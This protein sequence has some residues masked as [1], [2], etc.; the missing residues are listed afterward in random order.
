VPTSQARR[1]L[2]VCQGRLAALA[3][4]WASHSCRLRG[5]AHTLN[6]IRRRLRLLLGHLFFVAF[7]AFP[8]LLG[9]DDLACVLSEHLI[10]TDVSGSERP[11]AFHRL[12]ITG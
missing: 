1:E 7:L 10:C 6:H 4:R 9:V 8:Q 11:K 12:S 3:L 2:L 5:R